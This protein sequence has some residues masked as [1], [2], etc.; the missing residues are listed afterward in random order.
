MLGS[1]HSCPWLHVAYGLEV[2]CALKL[3]GIGSMTKS[4]LSNSLLCDLM[5]KALSKP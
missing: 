5:R 4:L 2:E 3:F 1:I